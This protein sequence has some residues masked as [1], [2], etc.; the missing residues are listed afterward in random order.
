MGLT[1]KVADLRRTAPAESA[2][3]WQQAYQSQVQENDVEMDE[4]EKQGIKEAEEEGK[5]DLG[6]L[7]R[8]DEVRDTWAKGTEE[9]LALKGGLTETVAR[10]E[11]AKTVVGYMQGR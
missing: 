2:T 5:V 1:E 7:E 9:L 8:W 6:D 11:R 10:L 3:R 4:Q